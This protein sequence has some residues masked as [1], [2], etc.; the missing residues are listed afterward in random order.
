MRKKYLHKIA[1]KTGYKYIIAIR[2]KYFISRVNY[3]E[4]MEIYNECVECGFDENEVER[5]KEKYKERK[6]NDAMKYVGKNQSGYYFIQRG[7]KYYCSSPDLDEILKYKKQ[8]EENNWDKSCLNYKFRKKH[9]LPK[10]IQKNRSGRYCI[11]YKGKHYGTFSTLDDAIE[12]RDL[13]MV[14]DW[15]YDF[16]DLM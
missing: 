5:I 13:L 11:Q 12:E 3:D 2:S 16:I 1:T 15:D 4:I 7:G 9:N 6:L 10:Y 8:L 14:N